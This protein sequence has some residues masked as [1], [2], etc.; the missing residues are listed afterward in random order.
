MAPLD[1]AAP[2]RI[3]VRGTNWVGDAVMT[4]PA[5]EALNA[6]CPQAGIEVVARPWVAAV[7]EAHPAVQRVHHL[8]AHTAHKWAWGRVRLARELGRE[9]F[10]WAVLF[11]NAFEAA[12][13]AWLAR[14]PVRV[15]FDSDARRML[16]THPVRRLAW[17]RRVHETSYYLWILRGAG[18]LDHDPP[19]E[20]VTPRLY[21]R[22]Q[23]RA[24]AG[25]F[26]AA[27][28]LDKA[29]NLVGM[30]PGAAFGPAKCWP[31]DRY[32]AAAGML[33]DKGLG[34]A[35][36]FGS[37]SE[38]PAVEAVAALA[39]EDRVVDLAGRTDLGQ[40]LAL[41]AR[42]S[43]FITNDS[44]LMHAAAALGVPTVAVFGSTNPTAT[45]PLGP[46]VRVVYHPVD[47]AP[48]KKPNCP[49]GDLKC[50][51]A[52]SPEEVAEAGLELLAGGGADD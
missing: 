33:A 38:R 27:R 15:G 18:L 7:Y 16:L 20:G 19:A 17:M 1:T 11:Q 25:E 29:G 42:L 45:G 51:T 41:L 8:N 28:G 13:I 34:P 26:L 4:L 23:D 37:N 24:W 30:A 6:A 39:G 52:I 21:I 43:L 48:C 3:M 12:F 14:V 9:H 35:L 32:A 40:A 47:C 2:R 10:D 44:G 36:L 50:L 49:T 22:D 5:L 46:R 31:A